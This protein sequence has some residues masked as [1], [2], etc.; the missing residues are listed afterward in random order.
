MDA[1][2]AIMQ[3]RSIRKYTDE[4]VSEEHIQILLDAAMAAPSGV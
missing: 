4:A 3:R 2:E 1:L